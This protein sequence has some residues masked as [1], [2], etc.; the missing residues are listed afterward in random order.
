MYCTC[1]QLP[2]SLSVAV[3]CSTLL[4]T[5]YIKGML[6]SN[7]NSYLYLLPVK[8]VQLFPFKIIL[9]FSN[10]TILMDSKIPFYSPSGLTVELWGAYLDLIYWLQDILQIFGIYYIKSYILN[11][12]SAP[13]KYILVFSLLSLFFPL[14]SQ[15]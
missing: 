8:L 10:Q 4:Y 3:H 1:T 7:N 15:R 5:L 13:R 2:P 6:C 11:I 14:I 9:E 12:V